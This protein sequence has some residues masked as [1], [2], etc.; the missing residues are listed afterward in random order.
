MN[1]IKTT[2]V[3][4]IVVL[5]IIFL[6]NTNFQ[7]PETET[8]SFE[9]V[10]TT[11]SKN[12]KT[13]I[14]T[15]RTPASTKKKNNKTDIKRSK[16]NR[17]NFS[18]TASSFSN[19]IPN[20]KDSLIFEN[21]ILAPVSTIPNETEFSQTAQTN[22]EKKVIK[23]KNEDPVFRSNTLN[24]KQ[25]KK[26][27]LN[28]PPIISSSLSPSSR[29][30]SPGVTTNTCVASSVGGAFNHPIAITL[31]CS[32]ISTIKF[33]LAPDT[34]NG[35]CD[36]T[37]GTTYNS[38]IIIGPLDGAYCLSFYGLAATVDSEVNEQNYTI[39]STLPDLQV[40]HPIINYQTTQLTGKSYVTSLDFGKTGFEIGQVNLRNHDPSPSGENLDCNDIVENYVSLLSLTPLSVLPWTDVSLDNPSIQIEI[41]FRSDQLDYGDNFITSYIANNNP[42]VPLYSCS[43]TKIV[44]NDFEFF[45]P[46]LAFGDPGNNSVREFSGGFSSFGFFE[47]DTDIS[48][49]PAGESTEVNSNQRLEYGMFGIIF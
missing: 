32:L 21:P 1:I 45:Q 42:V 37:S 48:R 47:Q 11:K 35:C 44:L 7:I 15:N 10:N 34:G 49:G 2:G 23:I 8:D 29:T 46:D 17:A 39:N 12:Q 31:S 14:D 16:L 20:A 28:A 36:P 25:N 41:P 9:E 22:T 27:S 43:T 19:D 26:E 24:S 4:L 18:Q 13:T 40:S 6:R 38:Q 33:C 5:G 3:G 30:S